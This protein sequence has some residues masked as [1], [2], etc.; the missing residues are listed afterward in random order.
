MLIVLSLFLLPRTSLS[1]SCGGIGCF[2]FLVLRSLDAVLEVVGIAFGVF[3]PVVAIVVLVA[4]GPELEGVTSGAILG[5][6]VVLV[7]V[8]EMVGFKIGLKRAERGGGCKLNE[9]KGYPTHAG[10]SR[11]EW[12]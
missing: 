8:V 6:F 11:H 5:V 3:V 1:C 2:F 9:E 7:A 12:P 10:N 4:V